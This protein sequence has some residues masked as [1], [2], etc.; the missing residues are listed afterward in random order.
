MWREHSRYISGVAWTGLGDVYFILDTNYLMQT[1]PTTSLDRWSEPRGGGDAAE[2]PQHPLPYA[3]SPRSPFYC[4]VTHVTHLFNSRI[5]VTGSHWSLCPDY[6]GGPALFAIPP[7][8]GPRNPSGAAAETPEGSRELGAAHPEYLDDVQARLRVLQDRE[9][10]VD[11]HQADLVRVGALAHQVDHLL[12]QARA[13]NERPQEAAL[14]EGPRVG[15]MVAP[16]PEKGTEGLSG[17]RQGP[18]SSSSL[19]EEQRSRHKTSA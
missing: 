13:W 2:A 16:A 15:P 9:L 3:H 12:Q 5:T 18:R 1:H 19:V 7:L 14:R 4:E 10:L 11:V 6:L 8:R 17:G